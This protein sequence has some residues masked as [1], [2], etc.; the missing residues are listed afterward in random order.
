MGSFSER[1]LGFLDTGGVG[2]KVAGIGFWFLIVVIFVAV[3]M[4]IISGLIV[5]TDVWLEA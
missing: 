5:G 1:L 3:I 4:A 2:V